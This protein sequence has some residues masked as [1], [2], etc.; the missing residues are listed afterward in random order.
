MLNKMNN[1]LIKGILVLIGLHLPSLAYS[2]LYS[3]SCREEIKI[4]RNEPVLKR[5]YDEKK[6][7]YDEIKERTTSYNKNNSHNLTIN[8]S[9]T[10]L[11]NQKFN[12]ERLLD[13]NQQQKEV[14][15]DIENKFK[16]YPELMKLEKTRLDYE[17]QSVILN[18]AC[19]PILVPLRLLGYCKPDTFKPAE[20]YP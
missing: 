1:S 11:R 2:V 20:I 3:V 12:L 9:I 4:I 15:K 5:M 13:L 19:F 18:P 16:D 8:D 6:R 14:I 10:H 7:I 17:Y